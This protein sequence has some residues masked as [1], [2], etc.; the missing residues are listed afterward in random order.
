[1]PLVVVADTSRGIALALDEVFAAHGGVD[2]V[3]P[4]RGGTV[5]IKPNAVHFSPHAYTDPRVLDALLGYLRDHGHRRLAVMEGCTAG[6]FTRL[7]FRVTGYTAICR[8]HRAEAI[9]LDEGPTVEVPLRDG[10][11][12]H[13]A[14]R[15]HDEVIRRGPNVYLGL[16]KLKT[17]VMAK[18]TLGVKNQQ[19]L[20]AHIDRMGRHDADTLHARLAALYALAPPDFCLVEGLYATAHGHV[21]PRAL[22]PESLVPMNVL[23]GGGDTV[24]VDAVAARI[25][26]YPVAEIEHLRLC[27][28]WGLGETDLARIET[29]G[30]PLSRF[31]RRIPFELLRAFHPDVRW[32]VGRRH[33]CLEGCR[34]NSEAV[35]EM[36][37]ADHGGR[38]GWTLVCGQGFEPADLEG[39]PGDILVVG[40]C[41]CG[42]VAA[43]LRR[44]YPDRRIFTV[45]EH[46]DLMSV[47][48]HQA[49]LAGVSP[50]SMVPANPL[51][52]GLTLLQ[53]H[54]HGLHA[55]VPPLLG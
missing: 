10:T 39:L 32:V 13:V 27:G 3:I 18:V 35:Q 40:P 31:A 15:F 22:L 43:E 26:G 7:V 12:V 36:L 42:E 17:H 53:A 14:R 6:N 4:R 11:Q 47:T 2:E 50:I 21:P 5:F 48:R 28:E 49:R 20:P 37:Y 46:N 1:M 52:A 29:R 23:V 54:A 24:A 38:G 8:R 34:G 44:R 33:A 30:V 51:V 25:L 55:R 9:Y 16:P 19:G 45:P 41:A